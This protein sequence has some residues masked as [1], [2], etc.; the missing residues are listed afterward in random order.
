MEL[1]EKQYFLPGDV[2]KLRQNVPNKPTMIVLK[3]VTNA[4]TINGVKNSYFQ[5][6]LCRW[7]T[8]EGQL[9]ESIFNTKDLQKVN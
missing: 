8:T 1:L 3:K 4:I 7:F 6:L 5:G 9:Q 2:V